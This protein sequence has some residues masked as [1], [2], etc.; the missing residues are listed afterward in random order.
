MQTCGVAWETVLLG[1][2]YRKK[3]TECSSQNLKACILL[4][5]ER[6]RDAHKEYR[7]GDR[8]E[9]DGHGS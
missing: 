4:G 3:R 5:P 8:E 9:S 2:T 6:V 1:K 7:P